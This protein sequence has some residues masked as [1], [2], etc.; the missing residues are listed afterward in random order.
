MT[1]MFVSLW[2]VSLNTI[3]IEKNVRFLCLGYGPKKNILFFFLELRFEEDIFY[4]YR[5]CLYAVFVF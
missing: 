3:S 2:S 5:V 4:K 1:Y